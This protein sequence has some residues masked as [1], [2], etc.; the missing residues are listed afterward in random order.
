MWASK[1][2]RYDFDVRN[3]SQTKPREQPRQN[4]PKP[5]NPSCTAL[6]CTLA[7]SQIKEVVLA[8]GCKHPALHLDQRTYFHLKWWLL[9]C[10]SRISWFRT[11]SYLIFVVA[12][13][14]ATWNENL[15]PCLLLDNVQVIPSWLTGFSPSLTPT[16]W[17]TCPTLRFSPWGGSPRAGSLGQE[18]S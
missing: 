18:P 4:P 14:A 6:F 7:P 12:F 3:S 13:T 17:S 2:H 9:A 1:K 16:L 5:A 8:A 15:R 11:T 10:F